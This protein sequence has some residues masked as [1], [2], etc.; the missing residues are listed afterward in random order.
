MALLNIAGIVIIIF[1]DR[2]FLWWNF[3]VKYRVNIP[4]PKAKRLTTRKIIIE[5]SDGWLARK[6]QI[7]E[8]ASNQTTFEFELGENVEWRQNAKWID[9]PTFEVFV[10]STSP[11]SN[12]SEKVSLVPEKL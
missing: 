7:T 11:T 6:P 9:G 4:A 2:K 12:R 1:L 5:E 3:N 8:I 10:E